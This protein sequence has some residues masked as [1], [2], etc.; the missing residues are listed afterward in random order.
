[1]KSSH[2]VLKL[3]SFDSNFKTEC[4]VF[5]QHLVLN[6]DCCFS[7]NVGKTKINLVTSNNLYFL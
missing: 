3:L 2:S 5:I 7:R 1:M 4:K 6:N